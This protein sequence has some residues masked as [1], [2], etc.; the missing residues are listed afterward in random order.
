VAIGFRRLR[1]AV[2]IPRISRSRPAP[3]AP[4]RLGPWP[5]HEGCH[6]RIRWDDL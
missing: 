5:L 6:G 2:L 3:S 4:F 1:L